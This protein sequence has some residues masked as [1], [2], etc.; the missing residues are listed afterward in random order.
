MPL[1][2]SDA[3][4]RRFLPW[5]RTVE[6]G[7]WVLLLG[8]NFIGNSLTTLME[9]RRHPSDTLSWEPMVWEA[10]SGLVWLLAL[11]PAIAWFTR[12]FPLHWDN[13]R[14]RMPWYLLAS[15]A[16]S[17][18]HVA[19]MVAL[20]ML[21]YRWQGMQYD[22]GP[23]GREFLYEYLKDIRSFASIVV[24]MEG[25]RFVLRRWQGEASLLDA[26]DEGPPVEPVELPERFLVRK[27]GREFLVAA[28]DIEWIQASGN[29]VNL[30][31]RQH[32][33]PLRSTIAGIET[34]LDPRRFA[35]VHRSYLVNLDQVA[36]IEPLD[37]GDARLHLKDGTTLPCSRRYRAGLR[38][39][40]GASAVDSSA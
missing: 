16:V 6:V 13:W 37:T 1:S 24:M 25:Y 29:Y 21:V 15:V 9:I 35:R 30:R 5:Q 40:V 3:A 32:D 8:S 18:L 28:N 14:Q 34:K 38:G 7:F 31:V 22:F 23:W 12:R 39:R 4:Y 17:L 10:S 36:S 26:P 27:L 19:G 2:D 11:L 20:R 33:Y